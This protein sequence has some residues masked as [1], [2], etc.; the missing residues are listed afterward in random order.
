MAERTARP[1]GSTGTPAVA[2]A[3]SGASHPVRVPKPKS[4]AAR[5]IFASFPVYGRPYPELTPAPAVS[6]RLDRT[7]FSLRSRLS[8]PLSGDGN[9][10]RRQADRLATSITSPGPIVELIE[11]FFR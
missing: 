5:L 2:F 3:T 7:D 8:P 11:T 1:A 9:S 4:T 6:D 10:L